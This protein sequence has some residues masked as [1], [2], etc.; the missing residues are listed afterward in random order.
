LRSAFEGLEGVSNENDSKVTYEKSE[1]FKTFKPHS[2]TPYGLPLALAQ[3]TV[4]AKIDAQLG[5]ILNMFK[6]SHVNIP[7]INALF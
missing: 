2:L 5:M 6:E 3:R 1:R 7:L 4:K